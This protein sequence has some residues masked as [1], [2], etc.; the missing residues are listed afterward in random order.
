[1]RGGEGAGVV[2]PHRVLTARGLAAR[3]LEAHA[4]V[5]VNDVVAEAFEQ[6]GNPAVGLGVGVE[7]FELTNAQHRNVHVAKRAAAQKRNHGGVWIRLTNLRENVGVQ[8][9]TG[10]I[11]TPNATLRADRRTE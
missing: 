10:E 1:M 11:H 5:H 2:A 3:P 4:R 8:E 6:L 7:A 9:H